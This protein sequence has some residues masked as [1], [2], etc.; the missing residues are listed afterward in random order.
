MKKAVVFGVGGNWSM[1][2]DSVRKKFSIIGYIDNNWEKIGGDV[3]SVD[4]VVHM[5][6]DFIIIMPDD[7]EDMVRQLHNMEIS[8]E[9]I[10]IFKSFKEAYPYYEKETIGLTCYGQHF[11]DLIIAAIFGQIGIEKPTY[12]D[13][14]ANHPL[15]ISNTALFYR[16]GCRGINI[17][18]NPL[19]ITEFE[20]ERPEDINLN[21]GIGTE[22][23]ILPFYKFSETCGRNTFSKKEA[24]SVS[25]DDFK[26]KEVVQLPV[27]TLK[28]IIEKYCQNIFPDFLDCDIEGMDYDVL[29]D[30]DLKNNGPKVMC[31]E[32]REKEIEAFDGMLS[33]KGYFRY[34][35]MGENNIYV[36]EKYRDSL[37][38]VG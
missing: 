10:I 29:S 30:Y 13:L 5:K 26:V 37:I 35:R 18:A 31:V 19:L 16:N 23:G 38:H 21:V 7:C 6:F 15:V 32:V 25:S 9:K 20:K 14:G 36:Q 34:C 11:D 8:Y 2:G 24:D 3:T 12:M 33:G 28:S 17:E 22:E 27:V 4:N 1:Y